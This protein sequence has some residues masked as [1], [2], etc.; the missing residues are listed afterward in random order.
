MENFTPWSALGGGL[1]IGL[2]AVLLMLFEGRIAGISGIVSRLFPP[3]SDSRFLSRAGFVLGLLAAPF[4]YLLFT[5]ALPAITVA[6]D[7]VLMMSAGLLVGFGA[8]LGSGCTSGH[9]VC[10]ISRLSPRSLLA[11]TLFMAAGFI[12]VF[13]MRHLVG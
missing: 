10:G 9:G 8:V 1:L 11:T 3:Y 7:P 12:T 4:L 2:S 5:G 13:I 6:S